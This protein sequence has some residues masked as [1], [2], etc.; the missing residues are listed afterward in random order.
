MRKKKK[1]IGKRIRKHRKKFYERQGY[2]WSKIGRIKIGGR[3]M[4][5]EL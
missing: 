4:N 2:T 3:C 1:N 5:G